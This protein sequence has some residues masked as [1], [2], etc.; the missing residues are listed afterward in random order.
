M[1]K[2]IGVTAAASLFMIMASFSSIS[3]Q[4]EGPRFQ[5]VK[6]ENGALWRLNTET[7]EIAMCQAEAG[8][9]VCASSG[10][11]IEKSTM[12]A[13]DLEAAAAARSARKQ[14]ERSHTLDKL[15]DVF[16]RILN[17]AEKHQTTLGGATP[18]H[19]GSSR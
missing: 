12:N 17:I 11:Q 15:V 3:A 9:M 18:L 1:K 19:T 7:G 14:L 2:L 8:R 4:A 13:A 16:E 6:S 5:I 10:G